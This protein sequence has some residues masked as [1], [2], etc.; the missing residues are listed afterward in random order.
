M[1]EVGF[2]LSW[3]IRTRLG[4]PEEEKGPGTHRSYVDSMLAKDVCNG[5]ILNRIADRGARSVTFHHGRPRK[6][7]YASQLMTAANQGLM[8]GRNRRRQR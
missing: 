8:S 5:L 3:I 2:D 7:A 1:S 4:R 6:V